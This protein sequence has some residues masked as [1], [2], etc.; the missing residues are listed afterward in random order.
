MTDVGIIE[1]AD[2]RYYQPQWTLV[3]GGC[4]PASASKHP[5]GIE[6]LPL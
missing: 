1:P 3:G 6:H 5:N 4:A 2:T